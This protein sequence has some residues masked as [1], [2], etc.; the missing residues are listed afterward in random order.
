MPQIELPPGIYHLVYHDVDPTVNGFSRWAASTMNPSVFRSQMNE[1]SRIGEF[2][3]FSSYRA[4][5]LEEVEEEVKTPQ[6][7][8]WFD[9]GFRGV[10]DYALPIC[11]EFKVKPVV[12]VNSGFASRTERYW[13]YELSYLLEHIAPDVL[14]RSLFPERDAS[15]MSGKQIWWETLQQFDFNLRERIGHCFDKAVS[16]GERESLAAMF[17][18][19]DKLGQLLE[20]G[21][22]LTNHSETHLGI[23]RRLPLPKIIEDFRKGENWLTG[24]GGQGNVWVVPFDYGDVE[25]VVD[26]WRPQLLKHCRCLV[27]ANFGLNLA[28]GEIDRVSLAAS[29]SVVEQI[30][31]GLRSRARRGVQ[32]QS[33]PVRKVV[34][35]GRRFLTRCLGRLS[36]Q[37]GKRRETKCL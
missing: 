24:M 16:R 5:S 6:F 2:R 26:E 19:A 22:G 20:L 32:S 4:D 34:G 23:T 10:F 7:V 37:T 29:G 27:R 30:L 11:N 18:D 12:A 1:L 17:M 35:K 15:D 31:C 3:S 28:E 13:R 33:H 8:V 25:A 21:W 14:C 9:D 36:G